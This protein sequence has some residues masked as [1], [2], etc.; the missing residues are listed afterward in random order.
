MNT[1]YKKSGAT[2]EV[3]DNALPHLE[4][5][6]LSLDKPESIKKSA[7]KTLKLKKAKA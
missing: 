5:L 3:N 1:V 4:S 2:L 6:G 7:K